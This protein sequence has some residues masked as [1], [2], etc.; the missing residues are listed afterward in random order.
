[1]TTE[2]LPIGA[3]ILGIYMA[4]VTGLT[5]ADGRCLMIN[6]YGALAGQLYDYDKHDFGFGRCGRGRG[7]RIPN[8]GLKHDGGFGWYVRIK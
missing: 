4:G 1:M 5:P 8:L 7:F 6:Q 3:I 2:F